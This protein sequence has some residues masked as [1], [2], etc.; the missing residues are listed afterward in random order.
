M[1]DER[2][3]EVM[4]GTEEIP[5]DLLTQEIKDDFHII[6]FMLAEK[7]PSSV[8]FDLGKWEITEYAGDQIIVYSNERLWYIKLDMVYSYD[9]KLVI[10]YRFYVIREA[11]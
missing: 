5:Y 1:I 4:V 3:M 11:K 2:V 8:P 6:T 10:D 7:L 9:E